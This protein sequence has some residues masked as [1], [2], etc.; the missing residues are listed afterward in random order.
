MFK[1]GPTDCE[2]HFFQHKS[3]VERK[4]RPNTSQRSQ[5]PNYGK[6]ECT[7]TWKTYV[8]VTCVKQEV[9]ICVSYISAVK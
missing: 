9:H 1:D 6:D 2:K 7:E 8:C 5:L 3:D 4:A